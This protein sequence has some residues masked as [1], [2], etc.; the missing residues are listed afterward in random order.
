MKRIRWRVIA[1]LFWLTLF[2]N[3]ERLDLNMGQIDTINL[4]TSVYVLGSLTALL[5]LTP[6][7]Q[8][9]PVA[10]LIGGAVAC[11]VAAVLLAAEPIL[12]GVHTYLTFTAALMLVITILL[13]H[14]LGESLSEFL[15]AV[16]EMTFSSKGGQMP[17]GAEAQELVQREMAV[18]RRSQRPLSLLLLQ[19]EPASLDMMMH[20]LIQDIQR[21]MLQRYLL[22]TV[23]RVLTRY[24]RR[25]DLVVEGPE[26]GQLVL[27]T[28]ETGANEAEV[29]GGRLAEVTRER[30][31]VETSYSIA[32]F[33]EHALTYEALVALAQQ[34]LR[35]Q[36]PAMARTLEP[37]EQITR[38]AEQ[39]A[40]DVLP[41]PTAPQPGGQ[42]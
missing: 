16:E 33:P 41:A 37:E 5:A 21:T 18:S 23:A 15:A 22:S 19:T 20:R 14:K 7:F 6:F 1:L 31:G 36:R 4:P 11:Y 24:V 30:L 25:T 10:L 35:E 3:I 38:L 39:Q 26:P 17:V 27:L 2:F 12:G 13:A 28:P 32:T 40:H 34:R 29:L 9:Q 42:L 8:R